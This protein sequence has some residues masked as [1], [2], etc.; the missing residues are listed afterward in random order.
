[1][2]EVVVV[3]GLVQPG[4]SGGP[5]LDLEGRVLGLVF[6][7]SS[8]DERTGFALAAEEVLPVVER[9]RRDTEA[10]GTGSCPADRAGAAAR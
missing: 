9:T 3:R 2:R 7:N 4:N 5:L 6:A 1:V 10:V 8:V